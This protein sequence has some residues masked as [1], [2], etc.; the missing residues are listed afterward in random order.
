M[1]TPPDSLHLALSSHPK[2]NTT[3]QL[4]KINFKLFVK[5]EVFIKF[6][7]SSQLNNCLQLLPPFTTI[8]HH[9]GVPLLPPFRWYT[10]HDTDTKNLLLIHIILG[11]SDLAKIR[12]GTCSRVGQIG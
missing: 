4:L 8:Y 6:N 10:M 5:S 1:F 2:I 11:A 7:T 9:L 3:N 12:M